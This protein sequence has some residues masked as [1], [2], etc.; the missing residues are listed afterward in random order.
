ML[1]PGETVILQMLQVAIGLLSLLIEVISTLQ[2]FYPQV[3][4]SNVMCTSK[5]CHK[6]SSDVKKQKSALDPRSKLQIPDQWKNAHIGPDPI[7]RI[8]IGADMG[9]LKGYVLISL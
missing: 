5:F 2:I 8:A 9:I 7:C 6:L 1:P 3:C 4:Q